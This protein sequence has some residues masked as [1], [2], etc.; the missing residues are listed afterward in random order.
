MTASRNGVKRE[1][2]SNEMDVEEST[3]DHEL[4]EEN[5]GPIRFPYVVDEYHAQSHDHMSWDED[6]TQV[7]PLELLQGVNDG[8]MLLFALPSF[9]P[10]YAQNR[11][12]FGASE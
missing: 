3:D 7:S 9:L 2:A 1:N 12:I 11:G 6:D 4:T 8:D 5:N 10:I